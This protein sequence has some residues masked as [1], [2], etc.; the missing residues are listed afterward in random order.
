VGHARSS[1]PGAP[2]DRPAGWREPAGGTPSGV[3]ATPRAE[4]QTG[5]VVD[6]VA[7]APTAE[8]GRTLRKVARCA[9]YAS[10]G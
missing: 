4:T 9:S 2:G 1:H 3:L 5:G 7:A 8:P 10:S 6:L